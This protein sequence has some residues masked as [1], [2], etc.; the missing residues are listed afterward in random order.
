MFTPHSVRQMNA[1]PI[2][3]PIPLPIPK[4]AEEQGRKGAGGTARRPLHGFL[5]SLVSL[6]QWV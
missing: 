4:R 6:V 3:L 5:H 1:H 2:P